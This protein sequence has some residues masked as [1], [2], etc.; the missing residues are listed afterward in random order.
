MKKKKAIDQLKNQIGSAKGERM[1]NYEKYY[2]NN[3]PSI[4]EIFDFLNKRNKLP[5]NCCVYSS[6]DN[7]V[8]GEVLL[9][10]LKEEVEE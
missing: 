2:I 4:K 5:C 6:K 7:C 3:L 10:F 9:R 1:Y 8:C